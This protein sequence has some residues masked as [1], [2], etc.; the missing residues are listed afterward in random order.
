MDC[1][2]KYTNSFVPFLHLVANTKFWKR[3][4]TYGLQLIYFKNEKKSSFDV[5]EAVQLLIILST[6]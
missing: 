3:W 2:K 1:K 5:S 4:D 6:K